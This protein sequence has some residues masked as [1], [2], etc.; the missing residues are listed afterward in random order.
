MGSRSGPNS[1]K[2]YRQ[3]SSGRDGVNDKKTTDSSSSRGIIYPEDLELQAAESEERVDG[4]G[5]GHTRT[6]SRD[7]YAN[8]NANYPSGHL[9]LQPTVRT[10]IKVGT[11]Q[12]AYGQPGM[13]WTERTVD[14]RI[15]VKRDFTLTKEYS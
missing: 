7:Q 5:L 15:A 11:P 6:Q 2:Y 12:S 13:G 1:N 14:G 9:G 4:G 8:K 3:S 10:E